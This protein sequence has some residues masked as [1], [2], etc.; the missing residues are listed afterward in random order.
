MLYFRARKSNLNSYSDPLWCKWA[1]RHEKHLFLHLFLEN[2][3]YEAILK[4]IAVDVDRRRKNVKLW[5]SYRILEAIFFRISG[6][7]ERRANHPPVRA[8][9]LV[10]SVGVNLNRNNLLLFD[11]V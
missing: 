8:P 6:F 7:G 9:C 1:L 3:I 10:G 4:S 2:L 11:I 5:L